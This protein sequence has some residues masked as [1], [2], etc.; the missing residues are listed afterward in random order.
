[1]KHAY[2]ENFSWSFFSEYILDQYPTLHR[3]K[4]VITWV[5]EEHETMSDKG[6]FKQFFEKEQVLQKITQFSEA[7]FQKLSE[8]G[9]VVCSNKNSC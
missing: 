7:F 2:W 6:F 9:N 3:A 8:A 5:E 1:M 4:S